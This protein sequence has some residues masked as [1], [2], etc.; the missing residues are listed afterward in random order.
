MQYISNTPENKIEMLR[1][2]GVADFEELLAKVP[3]PLRKFDMN[4][5]PGI[6]ELELLRELVE[7]GH[8]N[9]DFREHA[10]YLGRGFMII[11]FRPL[12]RAGAPQ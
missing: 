5:A 2:I 10:C 7:I 11:L 12:C 1:A 3:K 4:I 9:H 6:S 8:A